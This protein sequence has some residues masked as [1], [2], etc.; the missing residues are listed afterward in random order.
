M[1]ILLWSS[2]LLLGYILCWLYHRITQKRQ[3]KVESKKK[4]K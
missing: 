1:K 2:S 4:D 3:T